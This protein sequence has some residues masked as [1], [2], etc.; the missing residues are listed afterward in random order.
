MEGVLLGGFG[1]SVSHAGRV[2]SNWTAHRPSIY[3]D[4]NSRMLRAIRPAIYLLAAALAAWTLGLPPGEQTE[5]GRYLATTIAEGAVATVF[6]WLAL[7]CGA[8]ADLFPRARIAPAILRARRALGV[9]A[10]VFSALHAYHGFYGWVGGFEMLEY[11]G[12]D[13]TIS[14]LAGL[15]ALVI[16]VPLTLTSFDAAQRWLGQTWNRL[17]RG[18]YIACLL[19]AAHTA[20]VTIHILDLYPVLIVWFVATTT[21]LAL[22]AWRLL[23]RGRRRLAAGA[24]AAGSAVLFWSTFLIGHH[25]H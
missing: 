1:E 18:V 9:S 10:A 19:V 2:P 13:Y 25:R 23:R 6:L 7:S 5:G 8:I 4:V 14:L 22:E 12:T 21:L 24:F 17:H 15:L 3:T 20:S 11:W 16:L